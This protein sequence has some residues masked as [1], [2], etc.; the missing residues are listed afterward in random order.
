MTIN[1]ELRRLVELTPGELDA[2]ASSVRKRAGSFIRS[3]SGWRMIFAEDGN[4]ES[5]TPRAAFDG[6]VLA[7]LAM[8][9]FAARVLADRGTS[10]DSVDVLVAR[11]TRPTG[12]ALAGAACL[13][14]AARGLNPRFLGVAA[15]PEIMAYSAETGGP[16]CYISASHNPIGHNG[17]KFG[18]A[19]AVL[20]RGAALA[21]IDDFNGIDP[22]GRTLAALAEG[23]RRVPADL[24]E[25]L[26]AGQ[27]AAKQEALRAYAELMDRIAFGSPTDE[28]P[29]PGGP[30]SRDALRRE[31]ANRPLSVV[32][33]PNG[34]AR[35]L[36][37]DR[38]YLGSLGIDARV[39]N[40]V[41]GEIAHVI[42]PEGPGLADCATALGDGADGSPEAPV[43]GI[44]ADND[45]DRGNLVVASPH[46]ATSLEAQTVFAL[47]CVAELAWLRL[48][49]RS[50]DRIERPIAVVANGPT[51][52]RID[53]IA[54][55][56]HATCHRAEVG[57]ANVVGLARELRS[58]GYLVRFLGEGS[59][60]GN[61]THPGSVRDPLSTL[62]SMIK[63]LRMRLGEYNGFR[64]WCEAAG[65]PD[66]YRSDF[67]LMD[68]VR[69]LPAYRTTSTADERAK[70]KVPDV[71]HGRLKSAYESLLPG[72]FEQWTG[73]LRGRDLVGYRIVN[74]EGTRTSLG[75]GNRSDAGRGGFA[76]QLLSHSDEVVGFAWMRGSGTEPVFRILVDLKGGTAEE[77]D[78]LLEAHRRLVERA[79]RDASR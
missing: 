69:T 54:S 15:A 6:L 17:I 18:A 12:D 46:G 55:C 67:G 64:L 8:D 73:L 34:G 74:Y 78:A 35:T 76:V 39:I 53:E 26:A 37:I 57:E 36:T 43:M 45:G 60:G 16:F 32:L 48:R 20:E 58:Q 40:G 21:L 38:D 77:E 59:N 41:P 23:I 24:P 28:T 50:G 44:V 4:E 27:A 68:V 31:L 11:D 2:L 7:S 61:I 49:E 66:R 63:L 29:R 13:C 65:F 30:L 1:T 22:D 47:V 70:M 5:I 51:S 52:G 10:T 19:G 62:M 79:A 72:E 25:R 75:P 33:D 56:F 71:D 42:V 14:L 3:V 9:L